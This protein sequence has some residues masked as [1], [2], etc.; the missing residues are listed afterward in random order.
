LSVASEEKAKGSLAFWQLATDNWQ[1]ISELP[2]SKQV[3]NLI[4]QELTE[5]F[6]GIEGVGVI[7]PRGI[8]ATK[9]NLIRRRLHE[10]GMRMTVVK[11]SLARRATENSKI[12]G[13]DKL[14]DGPSAIVYGQ[15][16]SI[17]QI[18]RFLLDESKTN[19]K[20]ELRGVFFDGEIY[21]G[22]KG[23]EAASKLPTREE[24]ISAIVGLVLSPGR[25][26]GAAL[27]G[28]GGKIGGILKAIEAKGEPEAPAAPAA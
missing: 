4:T 24:A 15:K 27:K 12:K 20:L 2:M 9:N 21:A 5:R 19:D 13:F 10:K 8:D 25:N 23:V 17:A 14:L 18:A 22:K 16:S 7:N 1:L 28:P 3:K 6:K 11:N 26:L